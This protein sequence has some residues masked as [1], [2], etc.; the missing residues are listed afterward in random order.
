MVWEAE[1]VN[2]GLRN[3]FTAFT[4]GIFLKCLLFAG[5]DVES[6]GTMEQ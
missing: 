1:C 6:W 5:H 4:Q 2:P 3:H